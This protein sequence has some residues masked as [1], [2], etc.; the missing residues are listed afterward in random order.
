MGFRI[1]FDGSGEHLALSAKH[2]SS[3]GFTTFHDNGESPSIEYGIDCLSPDN[4]RL[5]ENYHSAS[6]M[7]A[8]KFN[9]HWLE[10]LLDMCQKLL[11]TWRWSVL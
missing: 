7:M 4:R 3:I 1:R 11:G 6:I 5:I 9:M 10:I 8:A 2:I